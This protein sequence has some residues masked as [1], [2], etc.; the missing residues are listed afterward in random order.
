MWAIALELFIAG[1]ALGA[2][3]CALFCAPILL[4]YVAGTKKGF[5]QGLN[6][7]LT[8]CFFR[9]LGYVLL[10]ALAGIA[11]GVIVGFLGQYRQDIYLFGG[12]FLVVLGLFILIWDKE[13]RVY[14]CKILHKYFINRGFFSMALLGFVVGIS[15]CGPLL[16]V[17][18]YIALISENIFQGAFLGLSFGLGTALIT[19]L[20]ILGVLASLLPKLIF[21]TPQIYKLFRRFCGILLIIFGFRLILGL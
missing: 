5:K 11:G 12:S 19:P 6:T 17:L 3:R 13:P 14:F 9:L 10:G 8:F 16:G 2:S 4:P 1:L 18:A 20:I 7:T 15:P 21:K